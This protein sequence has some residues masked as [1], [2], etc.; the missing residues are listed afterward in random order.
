MK[1]LKEMEVFTLDEEDYDS[2]KCY[3]END[4]F[5]LEGKVSKN[6]RNLYDEEKRILHIDF[7]NNSTISFE[8]NTRGARSAIKVIDVL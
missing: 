4:N 1:V 8:P 3:D 2:I 7:A 6:L 5:L